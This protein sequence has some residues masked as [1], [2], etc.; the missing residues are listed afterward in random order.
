VHSGV[1]RHLHPQTA[2][3]LRRLPTA[4][5]TFT[6]AGTRTAGPAGSRRTPLQSVPLDDVPQGEPAGARGHA[7]DVRTYRQAGRIHLD[8]WYDGT[9]CGQDTVRELNDRALALLGRFTQ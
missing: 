4:E 2:A 9:R 7:L 3:A 8:W 6:D 1:L 5:V